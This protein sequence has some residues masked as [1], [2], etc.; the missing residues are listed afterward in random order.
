MVRGQPLQSVWFYTSKMARSI[1]RLVARNHY[2]VL[3]AHTIRAARYL[4]QLTTSPSSLRVLAM[5]ISMQ[6]NY[7]RLA[8]CERNPVYSGAIPT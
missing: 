5:Q 6:L 2:D 7:R 3:Y 4:T 1:E 8:A